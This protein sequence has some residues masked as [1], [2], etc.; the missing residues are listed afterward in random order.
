MFR[1]SLIS[2]FCILAPGSLYEARAQGDDSTARIDRQLADIRSDYCW[3]C[4]MRSEALIEEATSRDDGKDDWLEFAKL[5][6]K[7]TDSGNEASANF[8]AELKKESS[9]S[10]KIELLRNSV[11]TGYSSAKEFGEKS[12]AILDPVQY[13]KA[14][15]I[16]R[17][18]TPAFFIDSA[19]LRL[20]GVDDQ[21]IEKVLALWKESLEREIELL[22]LGEHSPE[23]MQGH[24]FKRNMRKMDR[25]ANLFSIL[26]VSSRKYV[27]G[28]MYPDDDTPSKLVALHTERQRVVAVFKNEPE[29][30]QEVNNAFA[31]LFAAIESKEPDQEPSQ[32]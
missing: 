8:Q 32:R 4:V 27:L 10:K 7:Y 21:G 23:E 22:A 28:V 20:S 3:R 14:L 12:M 9:T 25:A 1:L 11:E 29:K 26:P 2:L 16:G 15:V 24:E 31:R 19:V 18:E 6:K 13:Q 17:S 30:Q 5:V